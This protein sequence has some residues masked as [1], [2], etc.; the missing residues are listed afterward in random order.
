MIHN[1][2]NSQIR[3]Y[4]QLVYKLYIDFQLC[5]GLADQNKQQERNHRRERNYKLSVL[6]RMPKTL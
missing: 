4:R 5:P 6:Q 3:R 2:L 1:W